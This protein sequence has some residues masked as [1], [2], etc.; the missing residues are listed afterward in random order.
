VHDPDS[1]DLPGCGLSG[2]LRHSPQFLLNGDL[3]QAE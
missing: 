1:T 2:R 3:R